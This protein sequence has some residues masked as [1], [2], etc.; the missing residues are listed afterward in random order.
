L[1]P[2][3][4]SVQSAENGLQATELASTWNP[5][6][7]LMDLRM[8]VMD[9]FEASR[10]I[11]AADYGKNTH[12]IAVTASILEQDNT[13]V[14]ESGITG[15]IHKP[16]KDYELIATLEE[17]LGQIFVFRDPT[18]A[19]Q[20]QSEPA[21][22]LTQQAMADLPR[23]LVDQMAA[24]TTSAQFDTLLE[25]IERVV[26]HSPALAKKLRTLANDFQYDALLKLFENEKG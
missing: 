24:A 6:L 23:E 2:L 25:L 10:R 21:A 4:I 18:Q 5:E 15:Y 13:R 11:K 7:I 26:P 9:G 22:S 19:E 14:L 12:I 1:E 16:F 8:P 20:F 17:K 3:G